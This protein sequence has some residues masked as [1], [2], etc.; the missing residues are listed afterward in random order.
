VE[1]H[2][3][4]LDRAYAYNDRRRARVMACRTRA[5]FARHNGTGEVRV[6]ANSCRDRWCPLCA[7]ARATRIST[8]LHDWLRPLPHRKDIMLSL[9]STDTPLS[10]R[11]DHIIASFKRLRQTK[12]W[13]HHVKG[14]LWFL[15]I[16][17]NARTGQFHPHLHTICDSPWFAHR[18]LKKLWEA[19]TG[20]S[21]IVWIQSIQ[22]PER[23]AYHAARYVSRP[24]DLSDLPPDQQD[25]VI[26]DTAGRHLVGCYG[27]AAAAHVLRKPTFDRTAW[28]TIGSWFHV[29]NLAPSLPEAALILECWR[30]R[31]PLDA[32]VSLDKLSDEI[33]GLILPQESSGKIPCPSPG[34]DARTLWGTSGGD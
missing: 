12:D 2:L 14:G 29:V 1:S 3:A 21:S 25:Q 18:A 5:W 10:E 7:S 9:V 33:D 32:G 17:Y 8:N 22:D 11:I 6:H 28:T 13:K 30:S 23:A 4:A 15:Q 19:A 27:S 34:G 31:Q 16:T 24:A 20:D 26:F